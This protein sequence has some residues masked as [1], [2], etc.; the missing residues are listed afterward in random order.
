[1]MN[2]LA[3]TYEPF[4]SPRQTK[5]QERQAVPRPTRVTTEP[6]PR[7]EQTFD[8]VKPAFKPTC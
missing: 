7:I 4:T 8:T 5:N 3:H 6:S 1:M 2:L